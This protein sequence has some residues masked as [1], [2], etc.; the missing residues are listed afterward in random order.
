MRPDFACDFTF[1]ICLDR[2]FLLVW[3]IIFYSHGPLFDALRHS[4]FPIGCLQSLALF[5]MCGSARLDLTCNQLTPI[6]IVMFGPL[7]MTEDGPRWVETY[8]E[9]VNP[10][11]NHRDVRYSRCWLFCLQ[12][13]FLFFPF[14]VFFPM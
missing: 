2:Y 10:L 9:F 1:S 8:H 7:F 12:S 5:N 13:K 6:Y 3:P 14:S 11:R 4:F